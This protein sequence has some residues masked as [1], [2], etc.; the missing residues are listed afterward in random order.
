MGATRCLDRAAQDDAAAMK[1]GSDGAV[2]YDAIVDPVGTCA[3]QPQ[4][5]DA[6]R[7]DGPKI[8]AEVATNSVTPTPAPEGVT[9]TLIIGNTIFDA[10]NGKE[11]MS[12]ASKLV[13]ERKFNVAAKV[14]V[15]GK[16]LE[17]VEPGL[18]KLKKGV[19]GAKLVVTI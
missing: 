17:A 15:V 5:F 2:G 14:D 18:E 8:F 4:V 7:S 12:Y 19:S 1:A 16:G 9:S 11:V 13:A 6:L 3:S 10:E